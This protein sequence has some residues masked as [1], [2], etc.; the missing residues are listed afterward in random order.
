MSAMQIAVN[1][2]L[3]C[4]A[5]VTVVSCVGFFFMRDLYDRMH[6]MSPTATVGVG[7]FALAAI[8]DQGKQAGIKAALIFVV[9]VVSNAVLSHITA[10]A[11]RVRQFGKWNPDVKQVR[12]TLDSS[13]AGRNARPKID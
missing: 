1:S 11:A 10:R 2:L 6:Y 13:S 12:G 7:C 5:A 4:G 8:L 9:V 3:I